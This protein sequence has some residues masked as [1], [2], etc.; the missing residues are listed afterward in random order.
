MI[1]KRN[2]AER[3]KGQNILILQILGVGAGDLRLSPWLMNLQG[4]QKDKV[5]GPFFQVMI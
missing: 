5:R 3:F 4:K 1:Q 2:L